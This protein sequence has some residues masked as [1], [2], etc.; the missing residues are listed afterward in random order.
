V[1]K[2]KNLILEKVMK[3]GLDVRTVST[4]EEKEKFRFFMED[5]HYLQKLPSNIPYRLGA[6]YNGEMIGAIAYGSS[7]RTEIAMD[8]GGN[9]SSK[10]EIKELRR[11]VI[12][13]ESDIPEIKKKMQVPK[14]YLSAIKIA[15]QIGNAGS[16]IIL[17][18]NEEMKMIKPS[19]KIIITFADST[20]GHHGGVY[21]ASI[22][23]GVTGDYFG[24]A[25][26][27]RLHLY[28]YYLGNQRE[29]EETRQRLLNNP[30][31]RRPEDEF[32]KEPGYQYSFK[33]GKE[34]RPLHK[35]KQ[36]PIS[37]RV[38]STTLP[39][40]NNQLSLWEKK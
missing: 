20:Q 15:S 11:L 9:L 29:R 27:K 7:T 17:A 28:I 37:T 33:G 22:T 38:P 36:E 3:S 21:Q 35:S 13:R 14:W 30:G 23:P 2:L 40:P 12:A 25:K 8:L 34:W 19:L 24:Q 6:F 10:D 1:I 26:D 5:V 39:K 32:P 18:G 31:S 16:Q 4:P